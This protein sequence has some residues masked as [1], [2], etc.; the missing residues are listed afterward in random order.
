MLGERA[1]RLVCKECKDPIPNIVEDLKNGDLICGDCGF[2]FAD[3][4]VDTRAEWR[5][6]G[7]SDEDGGDPSRY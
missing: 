7:N 1:I 6:F 3:R 4:V 2:V 5:T